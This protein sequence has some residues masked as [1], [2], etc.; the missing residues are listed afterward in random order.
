MAKDLTWREAIDKVLGA[1]GTP[2]HYKE[3]TDKIIASR[4][5]SNL[6]ATPAATVNAQIST[7]IK[8]DDASPYV[9]VDKGT[10]TLAQRPVMGTSPDKEK[11]TPTTDASDEDEEQY[12]IVSSFGMF[13][14]R[15]A[16]QWVATPQLLGMQQLGAIP[17][18]FNKQLGI[19]L[20]Y[21]GREVIYIGR[22]TDRPLGRR[23]FEHTS[24]R[25]GAR[26]DRFSWFGLRP[27]KDTGLLG[28]MPATYD[29]AKMIPAL[30]AILIEA[31]EPR[32]NRKRGDDLSAV[33]YIQK[34]DPEIQKRKSKAFVQAVMEK[35]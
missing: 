2:L 28:E 5:R 12:E 21:D 17:V 3:I 33:E 22:T 4:L 35:M 27:V 19:Y 31:F 18:D 26:W 14:R 24:D 6:G 23:L 7:S 10:F 25:M 8:H 9:R 34:E 32:Q 20:L 29:A 1:A 11:L 15:E 13:W 30:E 16:I